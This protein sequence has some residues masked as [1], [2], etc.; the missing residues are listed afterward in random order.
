MT[1]SG[2]IS[3]PFSFRDR[4]STVSTLYVAIF[5]C[6]SFTFESK[7]ALGERTVNKGKEEQTYILSAVGL[8]PNKITRALKTSLTISGGADRDLRI[9]LLNS[10]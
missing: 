10:I 5:D 6:R 3:T 9:M 4:R 1:F 8:K 7:L 2:A